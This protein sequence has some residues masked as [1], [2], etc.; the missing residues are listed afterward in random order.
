M[1]TDLAVAHLN[2]FD[3]L[4]MEIFSSRDAVRNNL[5]AITKLKKDRLSE[6]FMFRDLLKPNVHGTIRARK[7]ERQRVIEGVTLNVMRAVKMV[8]EFVESIVFE[9][10]KDTHSQL[11]DMDII[12]NAD[13]ERSQ[14]KLLSPRGL[15]ISKSLMEYIDHAIHV[16]ANYAY[17]EESFAAYSNLVRSYIAHLEFISLNTRTMLAINRMQ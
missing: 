9:F 12:G 4:I 17:M 11:W 1:N 5:D 10:I 3:S 2:K 13:Y 7:A 15:E 6:H 14:M 16:D 8:I